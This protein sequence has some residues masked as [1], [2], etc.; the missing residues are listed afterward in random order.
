MIYYLSGPMTGYAE[1]N[2][3]A[4]REAA[5]SLRARGLAVLSPHELDEAE[6]EH[7]PGTHQWDYYLRRDIRELVKC[8]AI[9]VLS[10]WTRSKGARLEVHIAKELGMPVVWSDTLEPV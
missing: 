4:F 7:L 1:Y 5:A 9:A 3:P 2:F 8:D 10:G 6:S